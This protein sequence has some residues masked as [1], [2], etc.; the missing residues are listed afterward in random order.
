M[1]WFSEVL[2]DF[3]S[4]TGISGASNAARAAPGSG[5]RAA[6]T[7]VFA[8]GLCLTAYSTALVVLD[9]LDYPVDTTVT[10]TQYNSVSNNANKKRLVF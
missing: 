6:W 8:A 10:S 3:W 9:I 4:S 1:A 7:A 5:R 2:A